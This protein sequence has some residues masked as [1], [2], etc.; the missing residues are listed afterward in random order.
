MINNEIEPVAK[1]VSK[2]A[3]LTSTIKVN[4]ASS[5]AI[6]M[7][8][9]LSIFDNIVGPKIVHYWKVQEDKNELKSFDINEQLLKYISVHTLNGELYQDKLMGQLKYRLYL[10]KEI[11]HAIFS[12]F[13]DADTIGTNSCNGFYADNSNGLLSNDSSP[14]LNSNSSSS[15]KNSNSTKNKQKKCP[16]SNAQTTNN[17]LSIILPLDKSD[18]FL[19]YYGDA[20]NFFINSFENI[21]LEYKVYAHLK[22]KVF[23]FIFQL[24]KK[25]K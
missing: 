25:L 17:C 5:D 20:T 22:P 16:N 1:T 12:V 6:N 8:F 3:S 4:N 15:L 2:L 24:I 14:S 11:D 19:K 7:S 21:I 9:L 13:F 10:I 18:I 23:S